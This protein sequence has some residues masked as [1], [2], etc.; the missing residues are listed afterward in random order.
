MEMIKV[1]SS[2]LDSVGYDEERKVLRIKFHNWTYDY[3]RVPKQIFLNLLSAPSKGEFHADFIK[4][5]YSYK[6]VN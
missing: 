5:N 6:K 4:D 1:Q 2:N 3:F